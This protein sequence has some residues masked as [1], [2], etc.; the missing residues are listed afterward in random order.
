MKTKVID[1]K[2][3][4]VVSNVLSNCTDCCF[5]DNDTCLADDFDD[6]FD[7]CRKIFKEVKMKEMKRGDMVLVREFKEDNWSSKI[8]LTEIKGA[9]C[10]FICVNVYCEDEY[11]NGEPFCVE[12]WEECKPIP[13]T[14]KV[15]LTTED[16]KEIYISEESL[17]ELKKL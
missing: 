17:K 9:D 14:D 2:T 1:G 10:P 4:E 11:R 3:Y 16:G 8:F 13:V 6:D 5:N 12:C 7:C 15:K